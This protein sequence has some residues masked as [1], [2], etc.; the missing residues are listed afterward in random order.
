MIGGRREEPAH[1]VPRC[2]ADNSAPLHAGTV[3]LTFLLSS[4]RLKFVMKRI[5]I[6]VRHPACGNDLVRNRPDAIAGCQAGAGQI[7]EHAPFVLRIATPGDKAGMFQPF[8]QGRDR[9]R[10]HAQ[11]RAKITDGSRSI[12]QQFNHHQILWKG[13]AERL[14]QGF[15][16]AHHAVRR[17]VKRE[18]QLLVDFFSN[19]AS[20]RIQSLA[21]MYLV[22]Y[23]IVEP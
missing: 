18:R 9:P 14:Q 2:D 16:Q 3:H 17:A 21:H 1:S 12:V 8:E 22:H 10:V 23:M 4:E 15:V 11:L 5:G 13:Q 6:L 7:D 19:I 20:H